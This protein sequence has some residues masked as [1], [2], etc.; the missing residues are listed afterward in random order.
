MSFNY[1]KHAYAMKWY[2]SRWR[3]FVLLWFRYVC[4]IRLNALSNFRI[5]WKTKHNL[6]GISKPQENFKYQKQKESDWNLQITWYKISSKTKYWSSFVAVN[7]ISLNTNLS[8]IRSVWRT[9]F[10]NFSQYGKFCENRAID[11]SILKIIVCSILWKTL[12]H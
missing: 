8:T 7:W 6:F 3:S 5:A 9:A 1:T 2:N 11:L 12:K 10:F 4:K